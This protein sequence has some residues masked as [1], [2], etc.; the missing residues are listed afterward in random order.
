M[1]KVSILGLLAAIVVCSSVAYG[2]APAAPATPQGNQEALQTEIQELRALV[3]QLSARLSTLE[4]QLQ[5]KPSTQTASVAPA[6]GSQPVAQAPANGPSTPSATLNEQSSSSS[7]QGTTLNMTMDG[8]YAYNFNRPVGRVNLL[9]AYDVSSNSFSLNQATVILE[10]AAAPETGRRFGARLDLQFGQATEAMQ[11][12]TANELRPQAYRHVFQAYG[13]YVFTVG[14]GLTVDFGKWAGALG[15]E[16]NYSRDQI[17]YSRS[18][19]FNFLP[20][21]HMG[22][23]ASYNLTPKVN[24]TYWLVNGSQQTEDFNGFK[25]QAFIF[26]LKPAPT[27]S[28]NVNYYFGQEQRDVIPV[29]NTGLPTAPTQPG[30]PTSPIIPTPDGRQHIFDT[31]V[32]WNAT[33]KLTLVGEADYFINRVFASSVP[34]HLTG[35]AAYARYQLAP[36]FA[37]AGRAE[38]LSDRGGFFS[39]VTQ[40]LKETTFTAEYKPADGFLTRFE[41]RRDYSNQ[42]FFL[43]QTPGVLKKEQNTATLGLIWWWGQKQGPW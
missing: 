38:Y 33:P 2:Q 41:W 17:N 18:Y 21:Y 15:V 8:Y 12:S 39:G 19:L 4:G 29:L 6:A 36:K 26:T 14:S 11:G 22:F 43:T 30:L 40:A 28:W 42:P 32:T 5:Q 27:V 25:S 20:F 24:L 1:R 9:R 23:R 13:T 31:Y 34:A 10:R 35:G 3:V 7:L 16:G 37:L